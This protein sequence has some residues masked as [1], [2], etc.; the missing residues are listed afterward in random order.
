MPD[1]DENLQSLADFPPVEALLL[2][3]LQS[4]LGKSH[5]TLPRPIFPMFLPAP[6]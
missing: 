2:P 4:H 3:V 5:P 1:A 6:G